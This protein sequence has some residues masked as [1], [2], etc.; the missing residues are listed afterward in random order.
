MKLNNNQKA[1]IDLVRAGL[2]EKDARLFPF[3]KVD[4]GEVMRFAEEQSV[5]GLVAAGLEHVA[6]TKVSKEDILQFVGQALLLEQRNIAMNQFV[7]KLI[8]QLR[9]EDIY[10]LLVKG[11]GI[12]QCYERPLWRACGDVDLFLSE[13]NYKKAFKCL[14]GIASFVDHENPYNQHIEMTIIESQ[15][16][17]TNLDKSEGWTVE[18]HG[19]LRSGLWRSLEKELDQIQ[20]DV[21]Y[22]GYVRS[23]ANGQTQVF[24]PR[25]D[26]D[27]FYVFSHILQHFFF[28]G[29]GLR[30]IC[31]WCRLLWTYKDSLNYGLLESRIKRSGVMSEWKAFASFSVDW[32]GMPEE[33]I[34]SYSPDK[35]WKRKAER[36]MFFVMECGNFGHNRNYSYYEKYPYL[37]Y[38]IISL[39]RHM[40]DTFRYMAIFPIDSIKVMWCKLKMGMQRIVKGN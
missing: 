33:A 31:D 1:F 2:W 7:A 24:L 20:K 15:F 9:D 18:L 27:V 29:I 5:S 16:A 10:T 13:D 28:E 35:K 39:W 37:V 22:G 36:I 17:P 38:K 12:A 3:G 30:Q 21:F 40:T 26:E 32:L 6:D 25:A 34:P 19:T 8:N 23:W 4:Y 14:S 11:Q